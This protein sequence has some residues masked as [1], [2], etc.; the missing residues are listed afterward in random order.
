MCG[1]DI[2]SKASLHWPSKALPDFLRQFLD[3]LSISPWTS[4]CLLSEIWD[5]VL[6]QHFK[7]GL[8]KTEP[9]SSKDSP[10]QDKRQSSGRAWR[11]KKIKRSKNINKC[12]ETFRESFK[13]PP[14]MRRIRKNRWTWRSTGWGEIK[15]QQKMIPPLKK[16]KNGIVA[17]GGK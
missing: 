11:K 14:G 4:S 13:Q 9:N 12:R 15:F 5:L 7:K 17:V 10:L 1:V 3:R 8:E 16:K 2:C 6:S